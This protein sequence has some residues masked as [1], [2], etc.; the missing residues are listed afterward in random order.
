MSEH[1]INFCLIGNYTPEDARHQFA[2]GLGN[3]T[4]I[5]GFRFRC[6]GFTDDIVDPGVRQ[7][8]PIKPLHSGQTTGTAGGIRFR[9]F[10]FFHGQSLKSRL[11]LIIA[12]Q[13]LATSAPLFLR[14]RSARAHA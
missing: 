14:L 12:R 9:T 8:D 10:L 11:S 5:F 2:V 7:F 4:T 1:L 6:H 13:A 3:R